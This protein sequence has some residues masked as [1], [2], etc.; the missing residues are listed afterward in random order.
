MRP[1]LTRYERHYV[2]GI[3]WVDAS[4]GALLDTLHRLRVAQTTLTIFTA[5]T[6]AMANT[7]TG[8][9]A[10]PVDRIVATSPARR[11]CPD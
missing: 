4:I 8:G 11:Q 7:C 5:T 9:H 3:A 6:V 1:N 2:T 10:R